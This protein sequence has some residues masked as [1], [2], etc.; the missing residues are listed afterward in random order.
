MPRPRKHF[1][2]KT[3]VGCAP[4]ILEALRD[5]KNFAGLSAPDAL[6]KYAL[7]RL[8]EAADR[9]REKFARRVL[10]GEGQR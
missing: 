6:N 1:R 3:T 5:L 9:A 10:A 2:P 8:R 4:E 7:P